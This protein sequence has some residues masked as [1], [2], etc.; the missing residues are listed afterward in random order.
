M[1]EATVRPFS[2]N[3]ALT[4][5]SVASNGRFPT[6]SLVPMCAREVLA[7]YMG[8]RGT[9]GPTQPARARLC[10]VNLG[11]RIALA[12]SLLLLARTS[13]AQ[14]PPPIV[15]P[16]PPPVVVPVPTVVPAA[17]PQDEALA[18]RLRLL[19]SNLLTLDAMGSGSGRLV[20]GIASMVIGGIFVTLGATLTDETLGGTGP[21]SH[22]AASGVRGILFVFGGLSLA[23]GLI[24]L[25][26]I[27][28]LGDAAIEYQAMPYS[29]RRAAIAK[30]R[31]GERALQDYAS[32]SRTDRLVNGIGGSLIGLAGIGAILVL[33]DITP[34]NNPLMFYVFVGFGVIQVIGG[35]IDIVTPS[36]AERMWAAYDRTS[37]LNPVRRQREARLEPGLAP[38]F[39]PNGRITGA[40]STL[41]IR[42]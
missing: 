31:Y 12:L 22:E 16:T 32:Q 26:F 36:R 8:P 41:G 3:K 15:S 30:M 37:R 27:P 18:F 28:D 34:D 6:Q 25:L 35:V 11:S 14:T 38:V 23:D 40:V 5:G 2:E 4:S 9:Q 17:P 29:P 21:G 19:E 10:P 33:A 13:S 7:S 1:S 39:S 20:S 24:T 42:F